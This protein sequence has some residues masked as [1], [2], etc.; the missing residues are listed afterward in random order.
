MDPDDDL[1]ADPNVPVEG[2]IWWQGP[3]ECN[4]C[5]HRWQAVVP[6]EE[7]QEEPIMP[8]ECASCGH[9]AAYPED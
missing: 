6:I 1:F 9:M 4:I 2:W 8:L 5:S 7:G 3:V